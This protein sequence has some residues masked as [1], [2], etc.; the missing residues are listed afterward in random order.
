MELGCGTGLTGLVICSTSSPHKYIFTDCH[1]RVLEAI[2][3]NLSL[4][5][6]APSCKASETEKTLSSL[7]SDTSAVA[8]SNINKSVGEA[9][10]RKI[11]VSSLNATGENYDNMENDQTPTSMSNSG[12]LGLETGL[13]MSG[14]MSCMSCDADYSESDGNCNQISIATDFISY[15]SR[16]SAQNFQHLNEDCGHHSGSVQV[17]VCKLDWNTLKRSD[18]E[19]LSPGIILAAGML[20]LI[21]KV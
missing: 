7:I 12:V 18:L 3:G 9:L 10:L 16:R 19:T 5:G 13:L 14:G 8:K 4:N 21:N 6:F 1:E 20:I 11:D 17:G 15:F 2:Q